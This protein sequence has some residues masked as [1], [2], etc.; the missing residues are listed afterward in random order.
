MTKIPPHDI[1]EILYKLRILESEK[2]KSVLEL[3][4]MVIHQKVSVPNQKSKTMVKRS[5]DRKLRLRNLDARHGRIE[6]GAVAKSRKGL[7]GV[8]GGKGIRYQ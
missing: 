7:T 3:Y 8:D 6:S 1:L 2:L 5:I 4:D